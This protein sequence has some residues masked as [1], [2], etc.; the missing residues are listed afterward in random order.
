MK[1]CIFVNTQK[2]RG[3]LEVHGIRHIS[4]SY[5]KGQL[6]DIGHTT[7]V[8]KRRAYKT[9]LGHNCYIVDFPTLNH[10]TWYS[11]MAEQCV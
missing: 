9:F 4:E 10:H 8:T 11:I 7:K 5:L 1:L 2:P 6:L 3:Y